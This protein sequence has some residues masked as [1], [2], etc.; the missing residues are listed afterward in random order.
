MKKSLL[1]RI[2]LS[3]LN[4]YGKNML[5]V[6]EERLQLTKDKIAAESERGWDDYETRRKNHRLNYLKAEIQEAESELA[7]VEA[8]RDAEYSKME[9]EKM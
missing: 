8:T 9:V 7:K 2:L 3:F 4:S 1:Y 6:E 5:S